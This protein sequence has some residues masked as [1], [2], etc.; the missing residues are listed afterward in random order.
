MMKHLREHAPAPQGGSAGAHEGRVERVGSPLGGP[1]G[2]DLSRDDARGGRARD[3][4]GPGPERDF[5]AVDHP[6]RRRHVQRRQQ[7]G[8]AR[9]HV[10]ARRQC[11][12]GE[13]SVRDRG[14]V[15]GRLVAH[16]AGLARPGPVVEVAE[17][18]DVPV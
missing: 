11:C 4:V 2:R 1:R 6:H 8:D 9:V 18:E 5:G 12:V 3:G 10:E 7:R 15:G 14:E 17:V 13:E 16:A